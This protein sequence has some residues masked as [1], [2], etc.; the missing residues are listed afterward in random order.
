MKA[1][2]LDSS[3]RLRRVL[4]FLWDMKEHT[5]RDIVVGAHVCAVNSCVSELRA[6][7]FNVTCRQ[8]VVGGQRCWI[9]KLASREPSSGLRGGEPAAGSAGLPLSREAGVPPGSLVAA[10]GSTGGQA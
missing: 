4:D 1:A 5:T 9:Y 3:P 10:G 8:E 2:R 7:G 6:N